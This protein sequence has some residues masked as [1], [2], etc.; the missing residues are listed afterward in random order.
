[1]SWDDTPPKTLP[2]YTLGADLAK[3]SVEELEQYVAVLTVE[4]A[5]VEATLAA[6]KASQDAAHSIF[7]R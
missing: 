6:K 5:R 4:R 2:D 1:M 3:K 7:K